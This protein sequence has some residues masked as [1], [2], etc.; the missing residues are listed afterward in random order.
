MV[1]LQSLQ[2]LLSRRGLPMPAVRPSL[3]G[4][5]CT[6]NNFKEAALN[7]AIKIDVWG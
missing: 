4:A 2:R 6:W 7:R 3:L 1:R 5:R